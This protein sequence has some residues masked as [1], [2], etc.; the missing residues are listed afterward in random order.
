[1]G[2]VNPHDHSHMEKKV[3]NK[4]EIGAEH[5]RWDLNFLYSGIDD[6]QLDRDLAL[7]VAKAKA[8]SAAH[9]GNLTKTLGQALTD[10]AELSML[11]NKFGAYLGLRNALNTNDE[12]TKTKGQSI[13]K[14]QNAGSAE[15]MEF[16][17]IELAALP[18][19]VIEELTKSDP[20]VAKHRSLIDQVR[21]FKPH[22]LTEEVEAALTKRSQYGSSSWA[23]F[24]EE[25][26]SDLRFTYRR[27]KKTLEEITHLLSESKSA[28]ER[29]KI[30]K[31][32][33]EGLGGYYA[34]YAAQRLNVIIGTKEVED[35][36][37]GYKHPMEECNK[38]S[39]IPDA[40]VE[41]L[42]GAVLEVGGPLARRF[43]RLKAKHLK[44][45]KLRWSDR[46]APM[47]FCDTAVIP[48]DEA[49]KMVVDAYESFSPTLARLI[50]ETVA[51]K[52]IDVPAVQNKRGSAFNMSFC[53][54]GG[55][56]VAFTFLNY[57][58]STRDVATVAHELG[59]GV[60]GLL[61]GEAQGE[62]MM[63]A[64]M[65][66]AET[67]SVFGEMITFNSLKTRLS[68]NGDMEQ[69]LALVMGKLDDI[70]NTV[71]RQI[72]FSNVERRAHAH[73][74]KNLSRGDTHRLSVDD[75]NRI[76]LETT[77]EMYGDAFTYENMD[78]LWAYVS[79]FHM[80][81]YVYA[82]AFGELLTH[83]L[84]A[85]RE[86]LGDRFEPLYLDL[87]RSGDT[88]DVVEL[89]KPFGLDPTDP[90]FWADGIKA[91]IGTML[92]DA[93]HLSREM[94]VKV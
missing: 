12:A 56:P 35:R 21:L 33:N 37:R 55:K 68:K 91:S 81:F 31:L 43:Y 85:K 46:N 22:M 6:P 93:E 15:Y 40:V 44:L 8:F 92:E 51:A 26:S 77:K 34:K 78:Y 57:L 58:G 3:N 48:W 10:R 63:H 42:H 52:R 23:E 14:I 94:G 16:F 13:E 5:V 73:D 24:Y 64:P 75:F 60:H 30:L 18:Q 38:G 29:A 84:Y 50:R 66:Y 80:V 17:S 36:E 54:P 69:I 27:Q 4:T 62:L 25:I 49:I 39:R 65:A 72:G 2:Q 86:T 61:A 32:T 70:L 20:I 83:S 1:M 53:L 76:W 79:H 67:A 28:D 9:K 87:L 74:G 88:K 7:W 90:N 19:D 41:A 59:H 45:E 89:L 47:P 82:Y 11:G 71:V